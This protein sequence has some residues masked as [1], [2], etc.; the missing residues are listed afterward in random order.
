MGSGH[1]QVSQNLFSRS[2]DIVTARIPSG[3]SRKVGSSILPLLLY[4]HPYLTLA[5]ATALLANSLPVGQNS[6]Q[7]MQ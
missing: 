4:V 5:I 1:P 3:T 7:F 2:V 6:N